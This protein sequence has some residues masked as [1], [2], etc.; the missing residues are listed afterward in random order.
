[1][2]RAILK[3]VVVLGTV[4]CA[5]SAFAVTHNTPQT[6]A[7]TAATSTTTA[8]P[9]D[10]KAAWQ[11]LNKQ[12]RKNLIAKAKD[13]WNKLSPDMQNHIKQ[14]MQSYQKWRAMT[15]E[16]RNQLVAQT[17]VNL[18]QIPPR[19]RKQF[20]HPKRRLTRASASSANPS[21]MQAKPKNWQNFKQLPAEQQ[22]KIINAN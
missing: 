10:A 7:T 1:M 19:V 4:C 18:A 21:T 20:L 14:R 17:K 9:M 2:K 8:A 12:Q 11:K 13:E 16:Q 3:G 5:V 22:A 6:Q 15:P